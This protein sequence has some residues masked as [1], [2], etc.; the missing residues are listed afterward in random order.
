MPQRPVR[1]RRRPLPALLVVAFVGLLPVGL[2]SPAQAEGPGYGGG[3]EA[4][5]VSWQD[6]GSGDAPKEQPKAL[7][8]VGGGRGV[9]TVGG[10]APDA[11][12]T[13]SGLTLVVDGVGYRG[14]SEVE[15]RVGSA[16]PFT[17]R[18]DQTGTLDV[19]VPA[20][21]AESTTTGTS[22][23]ATGRSPSGTSMT[24]VGAIPPRPA[25]VGPVDL[26]PWVS[27]AL[28]L[29]AAGVWLVGR[30]RP[31]SASEIA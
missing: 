30:L 21:S 4:L 28:A 22:V 20:T 3:A 5:T 7:G 12:V 24:L 18:V 1:A 25:G 31:A 26:V 2:A 11:T 8:G 9:V 17:A 6:Q 10:R 15:V 14:R 27:A 23:V 13:G 29:G 19:G 16:A